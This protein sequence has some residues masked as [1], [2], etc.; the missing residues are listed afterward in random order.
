MLSSTARR[1]GGAAK[2]VASSRTLTTASSPTWQ[3]PATEA[4]R[5]SLAEQ[6]QLDALVCKF[7]GSSVGNADAVKRVAALLAS[8]REAGA[9]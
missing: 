4:L 1:F 3:L 7:G 5:E 6:A 9:P 8:Y 2:K